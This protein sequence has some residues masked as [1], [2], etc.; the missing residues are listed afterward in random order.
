MIIICK[1]VNKAGMS[2]NCL[3]EMGMKEVLFN[4]SVLLIKVENQ[5]QHFNLKGY[6]TILIYPIVLVLLNFTL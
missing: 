1:D 4:V 3:M 2:G 5:L 6:T